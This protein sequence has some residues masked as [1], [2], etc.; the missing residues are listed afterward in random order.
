VVQRAPLRRGIQRDGLSGVVLP[1][2]GPSDF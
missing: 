2:H 1:K